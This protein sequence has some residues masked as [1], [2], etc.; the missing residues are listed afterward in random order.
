MSQTACINL[1]A[2][3]GFKR[4]KITAD[5]PRPLTSSLCLPVPL[6]M[7]ICNASCKVAVV[8]HQHHRCIRG[9][10]GM[11]AAVDD[12][13]LEEPAAG[14]LMAS[15][16]NACLVSHSKNQYLLAR[17]DCGQPPMSHK[18]HCRESPRGL[19][20][21]SSVAEQDRLNASVECAAPGCCMLAAMV[22]PGREGKRPC[23][24]VRWRTQ[25]VCCTRI[26]SMRVGQKPLGQRVSRNAV[27]IAWRNACNAPAH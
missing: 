27:N 26:R 6:G 7:E 18:L 2:D 10:L 11:K 8:V 4:P 17:L 16:R 24:A 20:C 14:S 9:V 15:S 23:Q 5:V 13:L 21:M 22:R 12:C 1:Q 3:I 25:L 19:L